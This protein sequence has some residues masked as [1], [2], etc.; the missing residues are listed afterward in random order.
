MLTKKTRYA[1]RALVVLAE[2]DTSSP[3]L[4]GELAAS[5]GIPHK[6][7]EAILRELRQHG[8]LRAQ[9]GRGGGVALRVDPRQL[10]LASVIRVLDGPLIP[11]PCVTE[12]GE[13]RC[14]EC[15]HRQSCGV[16]VVMRELYDSTARLLENTSLADL[17]RI[18]RAPEGGSA[19][20]PYAI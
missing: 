6:F 10:S 11:L 8:I 19:P 17:I 20:S 12:K 13:Q 3:T 4:I 18:S 1:L 9:R 2:R 14:E 16:R 5:E 7:L 15:R